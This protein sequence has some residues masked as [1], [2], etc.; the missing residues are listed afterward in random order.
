MTCLGIILLAACSPAVFSSSGVQSLGQVSPSP[1]LTG[2]P[3]PSETPLPPTSTAS[4]MP[5]STATPTP[6]HT[7]TATAT[8]SPTITP[9]ATWI[10]QAGGQVQ[11]PILLYH[12]IAAAEVANRYYVSP[13]SF[14]QQMQLLFEGG[15]TT[16]TPTMLSTVL[17]SGGELPARPVIITF[18]DGNF[19]VYENAFPVMKE[20][21][22][23]GAVYIVADYLNAASFLTDKDI[24]ELSQA[25]WEIGSH[26]TGHIDLSQNHDFIRIELINSRL[27]I[28][29]LTGI[30]VKSFAYP[31]GLVDEFVLFKTQDYGY[32]TGMGLGLSTIHTTGRL[33]Y[34]DRLEIKAD[35]DLAKFASLLPW[36]VPLP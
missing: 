24:K 7:S 16:I 26:G 11:V 5:T 10:Y 33:F 6:T 30:P 35:Y 15:Y 25:G 20:F 3:V 21:G 29:E 19:S 18:D 2:S 17:L 8:A 23:T 13:E 36:A 14:R 32:T 22:F 34:L 27:K 9:T 4:Q 12:H 31:F 1:T 28:E